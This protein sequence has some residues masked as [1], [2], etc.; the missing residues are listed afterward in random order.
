MS[1][2]HHRAAK[3]PEL[4]PMMP[5]QTPG[6]FKVEGH[7]TVKHPALAIEHASRYL[8]CYQ[9]NEASLVFKDSLN[10]ERAVILL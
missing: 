7:V 9:R 1:P 10:L 4:L 3:A 2:K 5:S 6:R 8:E